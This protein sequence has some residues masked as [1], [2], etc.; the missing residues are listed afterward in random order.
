MNGNRI[1]VLEDD[2]ETLA[3]VSLVLRGEGYE[4]YER[5]LLLE[6]VAEVKYLSPSLMIIDVFQG[7]EPAGWEFI[8]HLK[9]HPAT[10]SIPIIVYTAGSL[11][12]EQ[13]QQSKHQG[14]P[15]VYKPFD[16]NELL[17]LIRSLIE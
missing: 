11:T 17:R 5:D 6:H 10:A 1:L 9:A 8:Q 7:A 12:A 16:L 13:L 15:V 4:V 2:D 14:I 3:F